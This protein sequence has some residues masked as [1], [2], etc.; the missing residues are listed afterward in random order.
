MH[1]TPHRWH[2]LLVDRLLG[3][4]EEHLGAHSHRLGLF[5]QLVVLQ[6]RLRAHDDVPI[7]RVDLRIEVRIANQLDDPMLSLVDAHV[8]LLGDHADGKKLA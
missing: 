6:H 3:V 8:Q 2:V 4:V 5:D 1:L 7:L